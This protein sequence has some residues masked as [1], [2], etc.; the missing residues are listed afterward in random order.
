MQV[1]S[2]V[3]TMQA[4]GHDKPML[5]AAS[6]PPLQRSQERGT[7][8]S[9]TGKKKER[10]KDGPP[11]FP[12]VKEL[13]FSFWDQL[14]EEQAERPHA[15]PDSEKKISV[16]YLCFWTLGLGLLL[17]LLLTSSIQTRRIAAL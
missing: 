3:R 5:Q 7:R 11:A 12:V 15:R 4:A 8:S 9:G 10:R 17:R 2:A 14:R 16:L 1:M 6:Y 13:K